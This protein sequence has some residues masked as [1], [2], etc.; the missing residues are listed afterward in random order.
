MEEEAVG[1]LV[2]EFEIGSDLLKNKNSLP[3]GFD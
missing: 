3:G 1:E 2:L